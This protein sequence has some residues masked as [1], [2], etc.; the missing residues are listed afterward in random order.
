MLAVLGRLDP[1][2]AYM[3]DDSANVGGTVK[4][5]TPT[6]SQHESLSR[7]AKLGRASG[8]LGT[9]AIALL[10]LGLPLTYGIA[11]LFNSQA[12]LFVLGGG[13]ALLVFGSASVGLVFGLVAR[14]SGTGAIVGIV[15]SMLA[16]VMAL[17]S[18]G[19]MFWLA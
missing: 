17:A 11:V 15:T 3:P 16:P 10:L 12:T 1:P 2:E 5:A 8:V 13:S 6:P 14:H 7:N 19:F 18:F 9:T 4:K